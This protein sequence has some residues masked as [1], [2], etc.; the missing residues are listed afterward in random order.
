MI[1]ASSISQIGERSGTPDGRKFASLLAS[2][3][4]LAWRW[5]LP[6]MR[7]AFLSDTADRVGG[8]ERYLSDLGMGLA[9]EGHEVVVLTP[10]NDVVAFLRSRTNGAV[11]IRTLGAPWDLDVPMPG[12]L[13]RLPRPL[14]RLASALRGVRPDILHSNNGGYPGSH[15]NRLAAFLTGA[16]RVMTVNTWPQPRPEQ[17]SR[18][19]T[20][21]DRRLWTALDRVIAPAQATGDRLISLRE[22]PAQKL[23]VI[24]Y[25][26]D[27]PIAAPDEVRRLRAELASPDDL[28]IGMVVAP[29]TG[30]D[31]RYKGH[32]V[33]LAALADAGRRDVRTVIVGHDPG[34]DFR[35]EAAER[36]VAEQIVIHGGFRASP[37]YMAAIDVLVMPSTRYEALPLVILEAMASSKPVLASAVSG[38]PEAVIDGHNG[39]LFEPGNA[40][41][42]SGLIT[43]LAADRARLPA[44][45]ENAQRTY[46]ERFSRTR[47]V[48]DTIA[49]YDEV[50]SR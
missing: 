42:L 17:L 25:G 45:G 47:M 35:R 24:P 48:R 41:Q 3:R 16:P 36:G 32:D 20:M 28:L 9:E 5:L 21:F 46:A 27:P 40:A 34:D 39:Y 7:I 1:G 13:L 30:P 6:R 26:I 2:E 44:L 23:T 12:V 14:A 22:L 19:N 49:V 11:S 38:V 33:L 43:T 8:A 37:P 31:I 50:Q 29:S 4:V 18:A 10:D 15:I